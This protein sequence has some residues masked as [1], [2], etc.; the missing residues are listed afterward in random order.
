VRCAVELSG[1]TRSPVSTGTPTLSML[2]GAGPHPVWSTQPHLSCSKNPKFSA[3]SSDAELELLIT[4]PA[5]TDPLESGYGDVAHGQWPVVLFA[6]A[7]SYA[8]CRL[9]DAYSTLHEQWA[10]WGYVVASVD[11]S[12]L[13]EKNS[14]TNLEGRRDDMMA[15]WGTLETMARDPDSPL[16]GKVDTDSLILAGH[17][18]GA[19]AALLASRWMP[20]AQGL[21]WLQG[22][23]TAGYHL[24]HPDTRVPSVG[25]VAELDRDIRFPKAEPT[26]DQ[27]TG[28][29]AWIT[30]SGGIHAYTSDDLSPKSK[31]TPRL[32]RSEQLSLTAHLSTL[33]LASTVGVSRGDG[34]HPL[35]PARDLL[36]GPEVADLSSKMTALWDR[37]SSSSLWLEDFERDSDTSLIGSP[38]RIEPPEGG[39]RSF[40]WKPGSQNPGKIL[41]DSH[42]L[43]LSSESEVQIILNLGREDRSIPITPGTRLV[44]LI[45]DL[46]RGTVS[47]HID[48]P[49]SRRSYPLTLSAAA[50]GSR[51]HQ[52]EV[53][54]TETESF[55]AS[56][57]TLA[58]SHGQAMVDDLRLVYP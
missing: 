43:K 56:A 45:K 31:D 30:I 24:G 38:L 1:E 28:P 11:A 35:H 58:L 48:T 39:S 29:H 51:F 40:S 36:F 26:R 44:F 46:D 8:N 12:P 49:E 27:L 19:T 32:S 7:N 13:C 6:H 53:V 42:A 47:I 9:L 54:L 3:A 33:L 15:A 20:E 55:Q 34:V 21:I 25:V 52:V 37:G 57:L 22:V 5:A 14:K 17:S 16:H 23:D 41:G 10:S 4:Y 18:R 50:A 2:S